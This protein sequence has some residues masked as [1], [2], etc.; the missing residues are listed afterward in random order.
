[1]SEQSNITEVTPNGPVKLTEGKATI[2]FPS[3]NEVFYNPVQEFN[4]DMSI[5]AIETWADLQKK[6]DLEKF[7]KK[8]PGK[9]DEFKPKDLTLLEALSATGLRSIRYAKEINGLTKIIANDLDEGAVEAIK[10][11][12]AENGIEEG[13]VV[14]NRGDACDVMYQN[15]DH[16]KRFNCVDL[17]PYG[18]AVPF[19][20]GA[21]QSVA[22]GGKLNYIEFKTYSNNIIRSFGYY[23]Y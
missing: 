9:E 16:L 12:V 13:K 3:A 17:D 21:V 19:L 18:S 4:R 20:D 6:E 11:N 14:A 8:N 23:L 10:K 22:D 1:M 7:L 5:L 15:R 2:T